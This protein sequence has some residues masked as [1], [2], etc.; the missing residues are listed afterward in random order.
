MCLNGF[1]PSVLVERSSQ[2]V[3]EGLSGM[4]PIFQRTRI[5]WTLRCHDNVDYDD[6]DI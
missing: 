3:Q 4:T 2:G 1:A 5:I 6:D